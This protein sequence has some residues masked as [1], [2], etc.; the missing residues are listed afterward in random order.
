MGER[1]TETRSKQLLDIWAADI[2]SL[3]DL[4]D[5]E[6]LK[7]STR[8]QSAFSGGEKCPT[9]VDRTKAGTVPGGHVL[10]EALDSSGTRELT[11]FLV[12]VMCTGTRV[13]AE[14]NTKVLDLQGPLLV[15]LHHKIAKNNTVC[16]RMHCQ[17]RPPTTR[18]AALETYVVDANDLA[19]GLFNLL[20]LPVNISIKFWE[21]IRG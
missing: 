8:S 10:V 18:T 15:D 20:Q 17:P 12:H 5:P 19:V 13:V 6:D 1:E 9:N 14:P 3:L 4:N 11:V 21:L 16:P 2:L 7:T